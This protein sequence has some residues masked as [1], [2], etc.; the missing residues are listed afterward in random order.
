MTSYRLPPIE[1]VPTRPVAE[2]TAILDQLFEPSHSL[3]AVCSPMIRTE[4]FPTYADLISRVGQ[5]LKDLLRSP[6][7]DTRMLDEI[8]GS[9]P[10]LGQKKVDSVQSQAEQAQ[11]ASPDERESNKLDEMNRS[12][13]TTFPSLRYVV[14]VKGRSRSTIIEDMQTRIDRNDVD[15]ERTEAINAM[16]DIALDRASKLREAPN[17]NSIPA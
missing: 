7:G 13:E 10:R 16:C 3:Y 8:L 2:Q 5:Q 17:E 4:K 15:A 12:Y 14:F 6:G 1:S 9:H 11:L